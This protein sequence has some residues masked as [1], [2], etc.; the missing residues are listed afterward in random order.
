MNCLVL[1][2]QRILLDLLCSMVENSSEVTHIFKTSSI[3]A[4]TKIANE[5][6]INVAILDLQL[7]DG[8]SVDFANYLTTKNPEIKI[9]VESFNPTRFIWYS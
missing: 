4:G 3:N 1:E 9:N 7:Q 6:E 2:D 8:H 5:H